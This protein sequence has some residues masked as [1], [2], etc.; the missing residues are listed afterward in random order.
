MHFEYRCTS[1]KHFGLQTHCLLLQRA[2]HP[3][4]PMVFFW[5]QSTSEGRLCSWHKLFVSWSYEQSLL[6]FSNCLLGTLCPVKT[7]RIQQLQ[8]EDNQ[9]HCQP[10]SA[11]IHISAFKAVAYLGTLWTFLRVLLIYA[12]SAVSPMLLLTKELMKSIWRP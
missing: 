8:Q 7:G 10:F 5:A 4:S 11:Q 9:T 3:L 12:H 6:L 2:E 1:W